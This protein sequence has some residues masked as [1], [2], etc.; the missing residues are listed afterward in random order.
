MNRLKILVGG[1]ILCGATILTAVD[2]APRSNEVAI[3]RCREGRVRLPRRGGRIRKAAG[4]P[5]KN[6]LH[7]YSRARCSRC[8]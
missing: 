7:R 5:F 6:F 1:V 8:G 2:F 4:R 3:R